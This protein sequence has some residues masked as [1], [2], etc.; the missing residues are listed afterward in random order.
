MPREITCVDPVGLE[1]KVV[2]D[3]SGHD[4]YVVKKLEE[5]GLIKTKG[6]GAMWVEESEDMIV[7]YT[8]EIYPGLVVC[9]MAVSTVFGLPRMGPT[10]GA[11]LLSGKKAAEV[12]INKYF[13]RY[14]YKVFC[15]LTDTFWETKD[16]VVT[17]KKIFDILN[18][19]FYYRELWWDKIVE[20]DNIL[21]CKINRYLF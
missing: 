7:E 2:V 20:V 6:F 16:L 18:L 15:Y 8:S 13:F 14:M 10:F 3:A 12:L 4:A 1:S 5:R 9:G 11:M 19:S 17:V 21:L